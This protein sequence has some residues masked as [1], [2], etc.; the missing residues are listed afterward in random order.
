[1][2]YVFLDTNIFIHFS[3]FEQ[4]D[5]QT[6]LDTE[7]DIV[8]ILAP[9]VIDELDKHKYNKNPKIAKRVKRLLP[10]I[11]TYIGNPKLCK[12]GLKFISSRPLEFTF[13]KNKLDKNEQDD[14]LLASIIEFSQTLGNNDSVV[15]I[16]NDVGPRLKAKSLNIDT[17]KLADEYQLPNEPDETEIKNIKLQNELNDLKSKAPVLS[18]SFAN[19]S[20]LMKYKRNS[21][22][23]SKQDFIENEM[24]KVRIDNPYLVYRD[25]TEIQTTKPSITFLHSTPFSLSE[26][27]INE[28]NK[29]L[30]KYFIEYQK[31]AERLFEAFVFKSNT[32]EIDLVLNNSG[33]SPALDIDIEIHFPDGFELF[34][35]KDTPKIGNKPTLPYRPKHRFDFSFNLD[36]IGISSLRATQNVDYSNLNQPTIKKTNSYLVSYSVKSLKHNQ[37]FELEKLYA[38]FEN[39]QDAKGFTIDYKLIVSN[40]T[41]LI[42]GQLHANFEE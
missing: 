4:L 3:D 40:I 24:V 26:T 2:K 19:G 7:K 14:C 13:I 36:P 16:T 5:W 34:R 20:N 1:M 12:H 21:L 39:I 38:K 6:I 27:Q 23:H 10:K 41:K 37:I 17:W 42:T 28:Y 11:E 30:D 35:E 22:D 9:I 29:D 33:T 8:I 31:Y 32:I 18:L 25:R 15:Y